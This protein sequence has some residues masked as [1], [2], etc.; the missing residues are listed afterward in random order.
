[1]NLDVVSAKS[2]KAGEIRMVLSSA[3]WPRGLIATRARHI[4]TSLSGLCLGQQCSEFEVLEAKEREISHLH[5][6]L[7]FCL[8]QFKS[9]PTT[10]F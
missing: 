4:L 10:R 5:S 7:E 9:P 1:M 6:C 3:A 8:K 2:E